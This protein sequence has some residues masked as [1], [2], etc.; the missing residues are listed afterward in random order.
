L[1]EKNSLADIYAVQR[2]LEEA[3][4]GRQSR[5]N[6]CVRDDFDLVS[7][8]GANSVDL[9]F[10]QAAFEHLDD[11]VQTFTDLTDVC[12]PGAVLVSEIDLKTHSRWIRDKDPN[13]IYRYSDSFYRA[14]W[15]RGIPNRVR[16]YKYRAILESL[17]WTDIS[18]LPL[19]RW[20]NSISISSEYWGPFKQE[21]N[22][23]EFLSVML[24]VR[25]PG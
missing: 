15:F 22:N 10:S 11:V 1:K 23:M 20:D 3:R 8:L 14:F 12:E 19:A 5:I 2:E 6:Y 4:A 21:V 13:N 18:I 7:A 9:V 25:K 16:P 17:G 24:C